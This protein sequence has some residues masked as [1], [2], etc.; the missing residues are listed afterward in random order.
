MGTILLVDDEPHVLEGLKDTLHSSSHR[1]LTAAT[2]TEALTILSEE[3]VEVVVSDEMMPHMRGSELLAIV[4][5]RHPDTVRII[6][7]GQATLEVAVRSINEGRISHFLQKPCRPESFR[8]VVADAFRAHTLTTASAR[9]PDFLRDQA[10][11]LQAELAAVSPR[12]FEV[13]E[14]LLDGQRVSRIATHLHISTH[15]VRNHL[16]ALFRKLGVHSQAE[17]IG[18]CRRRPETARNP[19]ARRLGDGLG[20]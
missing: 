10:G 8:S 2:G 15:T 5:H 20:P 13:L 1:V 12:E 17:L 3:P 9:M 7:T 6:L 18:K 16:K 19:Q 4:S 11:S 14:Y